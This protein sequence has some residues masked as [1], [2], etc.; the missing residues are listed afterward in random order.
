MQLQAVSAASKLV[1]SQQCFFSGLQRMLWAPVELKPPAVF[2]MCR[3]DLQ[4]NVWAA[5]LQNECRSLLSPEAPTRVSG[6]NLQACLYRACLSGAHT[7]L[8]LGRQT[9]SPGNDSLSTTHSRMRSCWPHPP[10]S[11]RAA[12]WCQWCQSLLDT[13]GPGVRLQHHLVT[14]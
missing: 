3:W 10:G 1:S 6:R 4:K 13:G 8:A 12:A 7:S 11:T 5:D 14:V 9:T 2:V